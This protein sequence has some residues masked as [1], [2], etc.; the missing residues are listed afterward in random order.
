MLK[1]KMQLMLYTK[2][3]PNIFSGSGAKVD[4]SGLAIFSNSGHIDCHAA[5]EICEPWV[6][7]FQGI[8]HLNGL[9]CQG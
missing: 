6:Q 9:K 3:Q 8:S 5:C 2:F 7:W 1:I 4:F